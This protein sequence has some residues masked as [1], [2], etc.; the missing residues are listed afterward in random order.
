[1]LGVSF[2]VLKNGS[3]GS[4]LWEMPKMAG[5]IGYG[6]GPGS[7]V[8]LRYSAAN[9]SI[10]EQAIDSIVLSGDYRI[11]VITSNGIAVYDSDGNGTKCG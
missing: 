6:M 5:N 10:Q 8:T 9:G 3:L 2:A 1:M 11:I 7:N 4:S